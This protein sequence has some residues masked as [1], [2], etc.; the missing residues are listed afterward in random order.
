[1]KREEKD[2]LM[3]EVVDINRSI[4]EKQ[5]EIMNTPEY[6]KIK[7]AINELQEG[8]RGDSIKH[9]ELTDE[10]YHKYGLRLYRYY[11][12]RLGD[13]KPSVKQGIKVGLGM[14]SVKSVEDNIVR[15]VKEMIAEDL[16]NPKIEELRQKN[17]KEEEKINKLVN[18]KKKLIED[19]TALLTKKK[20]KVYDELYYRKPII[21]KKLEKQRK[22]ANEKAKNLPNYLP[23][24]IKEVNKRLILDGISS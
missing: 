19:G 6:E 4:N 2:R 23:N 24:I 17:L 22:E 7:E 1:M 13:I 16:K 9:K 14:T 10:V 18:D 12:V 21:N 11:G 8:K 3:K 20:N 5:S 15:I